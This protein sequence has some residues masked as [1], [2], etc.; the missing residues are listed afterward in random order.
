MSVRS[1]VPSAHSREE[2]P[3]MAAEREPL[4][5]SASRQAQQVPLH[6][7]E[8]KETAR[9]ERAAT[10]SSAGARG[11]PSPAQVLGH[12][13]PQEAV[14]VRPLALHLARRAHGPGDPFNGEPPP[15]LSLG[16][17]NADAPK[18]TA[19]PEEKLPPPP[20]PPPKENP[21]M[22]KPSQH[23]PLAGTCSLPPVLESLESGLW[24]L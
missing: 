22:K 6:G 5:V 18:E 10:A 24:F 16:P 4:S 7:R 13:V 15:L 12:S 2:S 20:P 3:A 11:E 21:W 8:G 1:P 23:L 19:G 9:E 14:P 17:P